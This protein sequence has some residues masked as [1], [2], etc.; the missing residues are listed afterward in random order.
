MAFLD[1]IR[2][3]DAAPQQAVAPA[4]QPQTPPVP[5]V[6][7]LSAEVKAQA[8]EAA[9]PAAQVMEKATTAA[10]TSS[11]PTVPN[12]PSRGRGLGMER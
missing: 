4:P 2:N 9:R 12:A 1:F 8:V 7:N 3:R 11:T 6:Q 10:P 5:S